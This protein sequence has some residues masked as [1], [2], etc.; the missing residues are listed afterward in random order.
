MGA[1]MGI[2]ESVSSHYGAGNVLQLLLGMVAAE[3]L[4]RALEATRATAVLITSPNA[5]GC[6]ADVSALAE[7]IASGAVKAMPQNKRS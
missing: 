4:E 1:V 7:L 5:Y 3:D 2:E 6:C